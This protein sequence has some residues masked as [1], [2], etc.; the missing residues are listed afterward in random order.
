M[1]EIGQVLQQKL[2]LSD[3]QAQEAESAVIEV[4]RSKVPAQ[5]Q[6]IVNSILGPGGGAQGTDQGAAPAQSGGLGGL[7]SEAEGLFGNKG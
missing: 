1:N 4:I 3:A 7:L 6:G 5:F 2:G